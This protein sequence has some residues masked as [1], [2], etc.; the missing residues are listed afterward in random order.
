MS[1]TI[2]MTSDPSKSA[3]PTVGATDVLVGSFTPELPKASVLVIDDEPGMRNF[4]SKALV[5]HCATLDVATNTEEAANLLD[6]NSYDIVLLDNVMPK[7]NGVEWL[8]DQRRIGLFSDVI[9][10]TAFADLDTAIAAIRAGASDFLLKPF[11][12]NQLLNAIARSLARA[13]LLRQNAVL[14]HEVEAGKDLLHNS[15]ALLGSSNAIK[16]VR[17]AIAKAATTS[18]HVVIRGEVG[19]GKQI[20]AR[21]LHSNSSRAENPF[22]WLQCKGMNEDTLQT[23]LFGRIESN[24]DDHWQEQDGML[25]DAAGGIL[26]LE[27][28]EMLSPGCQNLL[29]ELLTTGRFRPIGAKR[30]VAI[31]VQI[32]S[33]STQSLQQAVND[34]RFRADLF[35]MLN[36]IEITLPPLRER[37][38][39]IVEL[40]RYFSESLS[41]R[42]GLSQPALPPVT[43][44]R[45]LAY[46]WP[47]NVMELRNTVE[48]ALINGG[49]DPRLGKTAATGEIESLAA[50]EQRHILETLDACGGNRAEA[51]R[52]LG[53]ARKTIDRKCQAWGL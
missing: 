8:A 34:N 26:Y 9:L 5:G 14:R 36:V 16:S 45:M 32:V 42:L 38:E 43:R 47:G 10:M 28:V 2:N 3:A 31:D 40:I 30:S 50:V 49:Y 22:V 24:S 37:G 39:D 35:Y 13:Q 51:A 17:A 33:S 6:A 11:R 15:D 21:M 44:R 27:D 53:V 12:V 25:R 18:S 7:Q 19:S 52:R 48:R 46:R 1:R 4:L 29:V 41:A 23:R 20:A